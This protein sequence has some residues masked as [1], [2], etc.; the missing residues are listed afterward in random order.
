MTKKTLTIVLV[1]FALIFITVKVIEIQRS[2][3]D[4]T[5][6]TKPLENEQSALWQSYVENELGGV[7]NYGVDGD[8]SQMPT[9]VVQTAAIAVENGAKINFRYG[10]CKDT[11]GRDLFATDY[12][13]IRAENGKIKADIE[14]ANVP[15]GYQDS[16][17]YNQNILSYWILTPDKGAE[18]IVKADIAAITNVEERNNCT[19]KREEKDGAVVWTAE[20]GQVLVDKAEK[21]EN[22]LWDVCGT[23]GPTNSWK[24]AVE[25]NGLLVQT[26]FGQSMN[27]NIDPYSI[28]VTKTTP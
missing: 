12:K 25:S 28:T 11:H 23:F 19:P 18:A 21:E 24:Q 10:V 2:R 3:P 16:V 15:A 4:V 22:P 17:K 8:M 14:I 1:V 5:I 7:I 27:I 6:E 26:N 13:N 20:P 9:C